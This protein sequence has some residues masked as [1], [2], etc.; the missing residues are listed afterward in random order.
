MG[1][2]RRSLRGEGVVE[3][4]CREDLPHD[5]QFNGFGGVDTIALERRG[6]RGRGRNGPACERAGKAQNFARLGGYLKNSGARVMSISHTDVGEN[7]RNI[8]IL[9]RLDIPGTE[10]VAGELEKLAAAPKK[11]VVVDVSS[12]KFL[13]SIGIRALFKSAKAVQKRGGKMV[14]VV[15]ANSPVVMSLEATGADKLIPMF[16]NTAEAEQAAIA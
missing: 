4:V 2:Q 1:W 8:V 6:G 9:G 15:G 12:L 7:L 13:A 16:K 5:S 14:L 11:G 3:P 10:S